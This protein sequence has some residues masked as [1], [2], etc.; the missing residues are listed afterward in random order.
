MATRKQKPNFDIKNVIFAAAGGTV[1]GAV[2]GLL[3]S[4]INY[5]GENPKMTPAAIGV[6]ACAGLYFL[7]EEYHAAFYGM[8]GA[9]AGDLSDQFVSTKKSATAKSVQLLDDNDLVQLLPAAGSQDFE[10]LFSELD[11]A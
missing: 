11:A 4:N 8:L 9:S 2:T 3:E 6:L 7:D 10:E 5:F 1:A